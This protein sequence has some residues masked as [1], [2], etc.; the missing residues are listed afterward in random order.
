MKKKHLFATLVI[1]FGLALAAD[2][3]FVHIL[4]PIK[5]AEILKEINRNVDEN[6]NQNQ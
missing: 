1:L 2:Y 3:Y 5:R 6:L 4:F